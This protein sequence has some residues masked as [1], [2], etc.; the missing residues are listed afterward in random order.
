MKSEPTVFLNYTKRE[1]DRNYDQRGWCPSAAEHIEQYD[2]NSSRAR[3]TCRFS[4]SSYGPDADDTYDFFPSAQ[5][6]APTLIFV[7]G[8]AWRNFSKDDYSFV[9]PPFVR[10]GM[11]CA[12]LNFSKLPEKKLPQVVEQLGRAIRA[13]V[14]RVPQSAAGSGEFFLCG[15]SSG[16]HLCAVLLSTDWMNQAGFFRSAALISGSYDLEPALLSSRGSYIEVTKAEEKQLSPIYFTERLCCSVFVAY[17][18]GDTDEFR[19]QSEAY[20]AA[21]SENRKLTGVVCF[22]RANHFSLI[23]EL[24]DERSELFQRVMQSFGCK[25]VS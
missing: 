12:V 19:R 22:P 14:A 2:K 4:T 8:G 1:L 7:H 21:A 18:D 20:A 16:A 17:C 25:T 3:A 13:V 6:A 5:P 15:H 11:N 10:S 23:E 9:A 24:A